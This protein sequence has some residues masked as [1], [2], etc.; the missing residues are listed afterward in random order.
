MFDALE[1]REAPSPITSALPSPEPEV[2]P[3]VPIHPGT[4]SPALGGPIDHPPRLRHL[5]GSK[6]EQ[7]WGL[8]V[9]SAGQSRSGV[10]RP[11]SAPRRPGGRD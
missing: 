9:R 2:P 4:H 1:V 11:R 5:T 3:V 10:S 8:F 6:A 7:R